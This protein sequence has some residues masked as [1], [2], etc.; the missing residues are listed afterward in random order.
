MKSCS[1]PFVLLLTAC[2]LSG[3]RVGYFHARTT[4]N[5]DG[6]IE[7]NILQP[8]GR[9]EHGVESGIGWS[10]TRT[11]KEP[12]SN[13][14]RNIM[15]LKED[16]DGEYFLG[17]VTVPAG[18]PLPEHY[19][20][21]GND[22]QY[23][24]RLKRDVKRIDYG[25]VVEYSW[26]E[27]LTEIVTLPDLH[28]ALNELIDM[29]VE[30][31]PVI[32]ADALEFDCDTSRFGTWIDTTG[33]Q[34]VLEFMDVVYESALRR[35]T[36][37]DE[38]L[39]DLTAVCQRHGLN[40]DFVDTWDGKDEAATREFVT[41]LLR[42]T[43]RQPDGSEL[44]AE[45]FDQIRHYVNGTDK[46][47]HNAMEKRLQIAGEKYRQAWPGGADELEAKVRHIGTRILGVHSVIFGS[48][49]QF[50]YRMSLPGDIVETNGQLLEGNSV[51]WKFDLSKVW[52]VGYSMRVRS[53]DDKS[54]ILRGSVTKNFKATRAN[55]LKVVQVI[56]DDEKLQKTLVRCRETKSDRPLRELMDQVEAGDPTFKRL[57]ELGAVLK[58]FPE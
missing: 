52:P 44:E 19:H 1:M 53:L 42:D 41:N 21:T 3:C 47:V 31:A 28:K 51:E 9:M 45:D 34:F 55:L 25:L 56:G 8:K 13:F 4:W 14:R 39:A 46:A 16:V 24:A 38:M 27:T 50:L 10:M 37:D 5:E 23:E 22:E 48:P 2:A 32:L 15:Q 6:S 12:G 57:N 36:G 20:K 43:V 35:T 26:D 40:I 29:G 33:R 11:V 7:R 30:A 54:E 18:K 49:E 58:R 17:S